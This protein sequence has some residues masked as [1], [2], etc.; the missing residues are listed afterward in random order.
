MLIHMRGESINK[1]IALADKAINC[2][3]FDADMSFDVEDAIPVLGRGLHAT[4]K[5]GIGP[6]STASAEAV[7]HIHSDA[8]GSIRKSFL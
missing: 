1:T 2:R 5:P 8:R 6:A 7:L 3:D 4:G